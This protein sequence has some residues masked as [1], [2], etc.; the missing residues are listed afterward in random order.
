MRILHSIAEQTYDL[1]MLRYPQPDSHKQRWC[2]RIESLR[3]RMTTLFPIK[4]A[5]VTL[6]ASDVQDFGDVRYFL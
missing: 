6:T 2:R 1:K 5:C 3:H 4:A